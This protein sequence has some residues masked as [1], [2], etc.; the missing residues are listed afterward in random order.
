MMLS[1]AASNWS[2]FL[3]INGSSIAG[4]MSSASLETSSICS[5]RRSIERAYLAEATS[6]ASYTSSFR[7]SA[8]AKSSN[9]SLAIS[10]LLAASSS[11]F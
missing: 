5:V 1:S 9:V 8:F 10:S 11:C 3:S 4:L 6:T 2:E 7:P